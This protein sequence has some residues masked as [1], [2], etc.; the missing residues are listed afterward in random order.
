MSTEGKFIVIVQL[1]GTYKGLFTQAK[2]H[3][4]PLCSAVCENQV[5]LVGSKEVESKEA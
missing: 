5:L 2:V 4:G 3:T 1:H